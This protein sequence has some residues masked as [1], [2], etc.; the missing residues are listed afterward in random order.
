MAEP[1]LLG[2]LAQVM[3]DVLLT[4]RN[5]LGVSMAVRP[6]TGGRGLQSSGMEAEDQFGDSQ[7]Q[8]L[9]MSEA[10]TGGL[11]SEALFAS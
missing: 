1:K 7:Q 5:P 4:R 11:L 2:E 8:N 6:R 3:C 9:M 10:I